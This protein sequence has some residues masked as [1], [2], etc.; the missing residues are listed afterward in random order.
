M[1]VITFQIDVGHL[2]DVLVHQ[3][4]VLRTFKFCECGLVL[5]CLRPCRTK[6]KFC[7]E[8]LLLQCEQFC[9]PPY[10]TRGHS[11]AFFFLERL[12]LL[13]EFFTW[14][15]GC[16]VLP[17]ILGWKIRLFGCDAAY[18]ITGLQLYMS[19]WLVKTLSI[20]NLCISFWGSRRESPVSFP[21]SCPVSIQSW[22]IM[23]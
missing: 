7:E 10:K 17:I 5:Q 8:V 11:T 6:F 22:R 2:E 21:S 13:W 15:S 3:Q 4:M 23:T 20:R 18:S 19:A 16:K 12:K 14:L 9:S 1:D